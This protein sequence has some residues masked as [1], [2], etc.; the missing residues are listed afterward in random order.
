M[1]RFLTTKGTLYEI[2]RVIQAAQDELVLITP[3]VALSASYQRRL[4]E[5]DERGVTIRLV[6]R[7]DDLKSEWRTFFG[8]LTHAVL[9]DEP[10]LH[11]KCFHNGSSLVLTSL[12]LY[13]FSEQNHEM[14][15]LLDPEYD[16]EAFREAAAEARRS[17]STQKRL[18][19][20]NRKW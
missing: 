2:E 15:V 12:N 18:R 10:R 7:M 11:A 20:A 8:S 9:Y 3:F 4:K 1:A 19:R 13:E 16:A 5:A 14:G 6:C 17:C